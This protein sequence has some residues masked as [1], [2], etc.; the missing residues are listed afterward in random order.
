MIFGYVHYRRIL[1]G[2]AI[3]SNVRLYYSLGPVPFYDESLTFAARNYTKS[4]Y[5]NN[6]RY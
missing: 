4:F 5:G 3:L 6:S 1:P 2:V